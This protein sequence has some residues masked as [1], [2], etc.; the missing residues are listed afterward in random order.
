MSLVTALAAGWVCLTASFHLGTLKDVYFQSYK[1]RTGNCSLEKG[2]A[3]HRGEEEKRKES[4]CHQE[5]RIMTV[6]NIS[7]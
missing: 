4:Y 5:N 1:H 3:S 6:E 2:N 7:L